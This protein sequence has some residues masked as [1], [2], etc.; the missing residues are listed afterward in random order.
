MKERVFLFGETKSSFG[1][2]TEPP[3][4]LDGLGYPAVILVT[5]GL[6]HRIGPNRLYVRIA[7]RLAAAGFPVLRFDL[8]GIGDSKVRPDNVSVDDRAVLETREAMDR[9]S[10][11][12]DIEQFVLIGLCSGADDAFLTALDDVR[13]AGVVMID[14]CLYPSL[15]HTLKSY[16][17]RL[18]RIQSWRSLLSGKSD[19]WKRIG[20]QIQDRTT[21]DGKTPA[22][23]WKIIPGERFRSGLI[24][25]ANRDVRLLLVY[26]PGN[27][28]YYNYQVHVRGRLGTAD[29]PE[30]LQVERIDGADHTF[31]RLRHQESLL[32]LVSEWARVF[33]KD[34]KVRMDAP[35]ELEASKR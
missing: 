1:I 17:R 31:T 15:G 18:L 34:A 23:N 32:R 16:S 9:L 35:P 14:P 11:V 6:T 8:S 3:L 7:R 12:R 25:L 33:E 26:S 5:A 13:V 21:A 10:A 2:V 19:L 24:E 20:R 30:N 29:M 22:W 27:S 4:N 28:A